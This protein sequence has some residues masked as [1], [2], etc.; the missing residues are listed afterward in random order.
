[1]QLQLTA[2]T[3]LQIRDLALVQLLH[4]ETTQLVQCLLATLQADTQK[5][6]IVSKVMLLIVDELLDLSPNAAVRI[7][8]NFRID[9]AVGTVRE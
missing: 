4:L 1:M 3:H 7:G 6:M 5:Q 8:Y 2:L 9:H